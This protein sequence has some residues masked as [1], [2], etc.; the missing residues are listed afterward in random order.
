MVPPQTRISLLINPYRRFPSLSSTPTWYS[1]YNYSPLLE[2]YYKIEGLSG[3][4][5]YRIVGN[6]IILWEECGFSVNELGLVEQ[7]IKTLCDLHNNLRSQY[8][9]N[10]PTPWYSNPLTAWF[11][12]LIGQITAIRALL[13]LAPCFIQF[14][15]N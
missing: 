7:N 8:A 11:L 10:D 3:P 2:L 9:S 15:K 5:D 6:C 4:L 1:C 14:L 13:L 12:P